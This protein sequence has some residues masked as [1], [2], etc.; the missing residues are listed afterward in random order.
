VPADGAA[1]E[2][3]ERA[4]AERGLAPPEPLKEAAVG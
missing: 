4:F 1:R 2:W 3:A